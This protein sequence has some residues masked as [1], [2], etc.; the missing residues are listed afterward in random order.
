M[1]S[2]LG[3]VGAAAPGDRVGRALG[4]RVVGVLT[5]LPAGPPADGRR[6][7]HL[8]AVTGLEPPSFPLFPLLSS[9]F[10]FFSHLSSS[11]FLLRAGVGPISEKKKLGIGQKFSPFGRK[12]TPKFFFAASAAN[13]ARGNDCRRPRGRL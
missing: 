6:G 12:S 2:V 5:L 10:F 1:G 9:S 7:R 11:F 3:A 8:Q 4:D 13:S